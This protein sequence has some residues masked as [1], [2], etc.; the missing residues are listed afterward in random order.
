M[1]ESMDPAALRDYLNTVFT[2]LSNIIHWHGGTVD[3]YIGDAVMAFWGAPVD[4]PDHADHAV[5]AALAMQQEAR[6][7][8]ADFV[9]RGL[10]PLA[11]GI[12]INTGVARVGDMGSA[13]RRTYT[14]LGDAVNLA[15]RLETLTKRYEVPILLGEATAR[16]CR[17][18]R[19]EELVPALIDGR[20]EPVRVFAPVL[21]APGAVPAGAR[22][23]EPDGFEAAASR[24]QAAGA[25]PT[26]AIHEA[27]GPRV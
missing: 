18:H 15:S 5:E 6:R 24:V 20:T 23:S 12:G 16:A 7:M 1:A 14:A 17:A 10:P 11:I 3:K 22:A 13:V 4:D 19:F 26:G 21:P 9:M 8:S 27:S 2:G 25:T